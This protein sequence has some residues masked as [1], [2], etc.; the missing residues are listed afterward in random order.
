[1]HLRR[2]HLIKL[3]KWRYCLQAPSSVVHLLHK[4]AHFPDRRIERASEET[5]TRDTRLSVPTLDELRA[6]GASEWTARLITKEEFEDLWT[7]ACA[8]QTR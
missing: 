2:T 7:E 8:R 1:M 6:H 4:A 5:E 3:R